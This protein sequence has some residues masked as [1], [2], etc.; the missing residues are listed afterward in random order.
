MQIAESGAL[1]GLN[2]AGGQLVVMG[3]FRVGQ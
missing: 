3:A 2:A 1:Y